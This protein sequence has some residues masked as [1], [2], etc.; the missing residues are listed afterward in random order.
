MSSLSFVLLK[1]RP[2]RS[3]ARENNTISRMNG[4]RKCLERRKSN[5]P[6]FMIKSAVDGV[7]GQHQAAGIDDR[8]PCNVQKSV[9]V[10]IN[11][12]GVTVLKVHD[13]LNILE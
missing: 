8:P 3:K 2:V 4:D 13:Q 1:G 12:L 11:D 9:P 7:I 5:E 6:L 10:E